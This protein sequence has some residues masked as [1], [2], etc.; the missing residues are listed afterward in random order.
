[1]GVCYLKVNPQ[2]LEPSERWIHNIWLAHTI[3]TKI[4][5]WVMPKKV[6]TVL[7]LEHFRKWMTVYSASKTYSIRAEANFSVC[8]PVSKIGKDVWI[9]ARQPMSSSYFQKKVP[10]LMKSSVMWD[11]RFLITAN[12]IGNES[13]YIRAFG[14]ND[15]KK[16]M[17]SSPGRMRNLKHSFKIL[18]A[19][20][21]ET[22]PCVVN[23]SEQ[24][25]SLPSLNIHFDGKYQLSCQHSGFIAK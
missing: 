1:L 16:L 24:I 8:P 19:P 10:L 14:I 6:P 17:K 13:L 12:N 5:K 20:V 9:F 11:H 15:Y 23:E 22:L 2:S 7:Q 18:P 3:F 25:V 4:L 21:R